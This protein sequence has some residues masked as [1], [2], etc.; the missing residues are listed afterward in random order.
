MV[1]QTEEAVG[2]VDGALPGTVVAMETETP[3]PVGAGAGRNG[4]DR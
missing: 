4:E 3:E 1:E 2:T